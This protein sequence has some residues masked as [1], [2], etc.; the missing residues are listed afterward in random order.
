MCSRPSR[1]GWHGQ[2]APQARHR[3]DGRAGVCGRNRLCG[4]YDT[5]RPPD[6]RYSTWRA[7]LSWSGAGHPARLFPARVRR[8]VPHEARLLVW[9]VRAGGDGMAGGTMASAVRG[10]GRG[11]GRR[12]AARVRGQRQR[13]PQAQKIH[14]KYQAR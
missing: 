6:Y 4:R 10:A 13:R 5:T 9:R 12:T 2:G 1:A 3:N 11:P 7:W 14:R 8:G